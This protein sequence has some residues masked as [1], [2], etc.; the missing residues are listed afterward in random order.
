MKLNSEKPN[1]TMSNGIK[2]S[3]NVESKKKQGKTMLMKI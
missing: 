3:K 1:K 2:K